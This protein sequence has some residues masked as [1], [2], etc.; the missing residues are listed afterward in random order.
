[1]IDYGSVDSVLFQMATANFEVHNWGADGL[2]QGTLDLWDVA[3]VN[4][5]STCGDGVIVDHAEHHL[6]FADE[7]YVGIMPATH[8]ENCPRDHTYRTLSVDNDMNQFA[9]SLHIDNTLIQFLFYELPTA[10]VTSLVYKKPYSVPKKTS[11]SA[12]S[13][14]YRPMPTIVNWQ[15]DHPYFRQFPRPTPK[16]DTVLMQVRYFS[17]D[18]HG[19]LTGTG[20]NFQ[21]FPYVSSTADPGVQWPSHIVRAL[22]NGYYAEG[23]EV[24]ANYRS[25]HD[26]WKRLNRAARAHDPMELPQNCYLHQEPSET[27]PLVQLPYVQA[28]C[29][30]YHND[31]PIVFRGEHTNFLRNHYTAMVIDPELAYTGYDFLMFNRPYNHE[32]HWGSCESGGSPPLNNTAL[33][34]SL[35][36]YNPIAS[37]AGSLAYPAK[38]LHSNFVQRV[39][40]KTKSIS[41]TL[42]QIFDDTRSVLEQAWIHFEEAEAVINQIFGIPGQIRDF[43]GGISNFWG[44]LNELSDVLFQAADAVV[45]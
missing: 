20:T 39:A 4:R 1:M 27:G 45:I 41:S 13:R 22:W 31:T 14:G 43:M 10:K 24:W 40:A 11:E 8:L 33:V 15:P 3:A 19:T 38:T 42:Q 25:Y 23:P 5:F 35:A 17:V 16:A 44:K 29:N 28:S 34:P 36:F 37:Y 12:Y 26:V 2:Q 7:S 32:I 18:N 9:T 30:R 21:N 6:H